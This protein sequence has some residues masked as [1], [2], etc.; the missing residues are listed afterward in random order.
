MKLKPR[1]NILFF[2]YIFFG[3]I[4]TILLIYIFSYSIGEKT[5][6]NYKK[7]VE[8]EIRDT[9]IN[10]ADLRSKDFA[11]PHAGGIQYLEVKD[12]KDLKI[13]LYLESYKDVKKI[14]VGDMIV[15]VKDTRTIQIY[16]ANKNF[17]IELKNLTELRKQK[18]KEEAIK[19]IIIY[20]IIGTIILFVPIQTGRKLK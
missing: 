18:I 11:Y 12:I 6:L 5:E 19:W 16:S 4:F 14:T 9:I 8:T 3:G 13:P 7:I 2:I 20:L 1:F 15:K 10:I 17:E